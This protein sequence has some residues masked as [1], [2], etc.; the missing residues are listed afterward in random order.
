MDK[1]VLKECLHRLD[2]VHSVITTYGNKDS[3]EYLDKIDEIQNH[4]EEIL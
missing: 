3:K 4:L 1:Q 2:E